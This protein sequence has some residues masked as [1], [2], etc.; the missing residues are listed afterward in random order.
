MNTL[1]VKNLREYEAKVVMWW[2]WIWAE[3]KWA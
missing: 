3:L 1:T 2:E